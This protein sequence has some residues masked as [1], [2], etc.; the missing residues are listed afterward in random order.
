MVCR[1]EVGISGLFVLVVL[2]IYNIIYIKFFLWSIYSELGVEQKVLR[3]T[4]DLIPE[5]MCE[6]MH[7]LWCNLWN[8]NLQRAYGRGNNLKEV[9]IQ[10]HRYSDFFRVIQR[11]SDLKVI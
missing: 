10:I 11:G 9:D 3:G 8:F 5:E 4:E 7:L 2:N 6:I 1:T